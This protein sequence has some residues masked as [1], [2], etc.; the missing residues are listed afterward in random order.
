V[1]SAKINTVYRGVGRVK[2]A[3]KVSAGATNKILLIK[4]SHTLHLSESEL[5]LQTHI[6]CGT[7]PL[8]TFKRQKKIDLL[9][10]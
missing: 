3:Y 1:L 2:V 4:L 10:M 5:D 8:T 7:T 6:I 9:D